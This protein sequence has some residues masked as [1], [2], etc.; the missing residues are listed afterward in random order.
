M[1]HSGEAT[2]KV[3]RFSSLNINVDNFEE[4][5]KFYEGVVGATVNVRP[6]P[7]FRD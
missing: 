1:K 2:L 7:M 5:V 4:T 6:V 3:V